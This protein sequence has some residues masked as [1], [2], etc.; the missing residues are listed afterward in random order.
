[1]KRVIIFLILLNL[2]I[3]SAEKV[4]NIND[5]KP[6]TLENSIEIL[7]VEGDYDE[8]KLRIENYDKNTF[9]YNI[10][11]G[12]IAYEENRKSEALIYFEKAIKYNETDIGTRIQLLKIYITDK[13]YEKEVEA[14]IAALEKLNLTE[15]NKTEL[16][17]LKD[18][19]LTS[20]KM[21]TLKSVDVG[22]TYDSNKSFTKDG[23]SE[24]YNNNT[25]SYFGSKDLKSGSLRLQSAITGRLTLSKGGTS[26]MNFTLGGEYNNKYKGMDYGVP[27]YLIYNSLN[28]KETKLMTGL[29]YEK[30]FIEG[31]NLYV[32][33]Q[34]VFLSNSN[35]KGQDLS[36]YGSYKI[37]K[38]INYSIDG[39]LTKGIY[40]KDENE[41][42]STLL[43]V[44]VDTILKN[45]YYVFGKYTYE[46]VDSNY[47]VSGVKRKDIINSIK[48]GYQQEIIRE[49]LKLAVDYTYS[50]DE[51]NYK[52]YESSK[53][54]LSSTIKW[55]F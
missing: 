3:Y 8:I 18:L 11:M 53:N 15:E 41:K 16:I 19:Y 24:F 38:N 42:L 7:F 4:I 21:K 23:D 6:V 28:S 49:G 29:N 55:E 17:K 36:V 26:G 46:Y 44:N 2:S 14:T 1:M 47:E 22:L 40:D 35:Y 12:K 50:Y 43:S 13:N 51:P 48:L 37:K 32:G 52:G 20:K 10:V 9:F 39:K 45:K 31:Q 25:F 54:V 30:S 33:L 27:L 34:L 5:L